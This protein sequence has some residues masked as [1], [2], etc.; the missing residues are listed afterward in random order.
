MP[1]YSGI[2]QSTTSLI[3]VSHVFGAIALVLGCTLFLGSA[4]LLHRNQLDEFI[5]RASV[6]EGLVIQNR[7][8]EVYPGSGSRTLP[9]TSYQAIVRFTDQRGQT[10]IYA[11][12][13]G[14]NPPSFNVGQ[15]VTMFYDRQN[16]QHAMIDRGLKN[17]LIPVVCFTLAGLMIFGGLQR[18][19]QRA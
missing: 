18:L 8:K 17:Y 1:S 5:L 10:V 6:A 13:F 11:D 12:K 2:G 4:I 9:F 15:R 3:L 19:S 14:F 16:P 7:G